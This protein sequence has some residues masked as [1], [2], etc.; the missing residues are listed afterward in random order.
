M[1]TTNIG[2]NSLDLVP[3]KNGS[4]SPPKM[5]L[6]VQNLPLFREK[7]FFG[8]VMKSPPSKKTKIIQEKIYHLIYLL[9]LLNKSTPSATRISAATAIRKAA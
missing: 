5:P 8:N 6:F 3:N 2:Q 1:N 7:T 9:Y 4:S